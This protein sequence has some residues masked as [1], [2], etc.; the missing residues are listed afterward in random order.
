MF[1]S[2]MATRSPGRQLRLLEQEGREIAAV[3]LPL[4][5]AHARAQALEGRPLGDNSGRLR[6]AWRAATDRRPGRCFAGT[7]GGYEESQAGSAAPGGAVEA[8]TLSAASLRTSWP[9]ILCARNRH[10]PCRQCRTDSIGSASKYL[11]KQAA[12]PFAAAASD[13]AV[14]R[15]RRKWERTTELT[16]R[17]DNAR[18]VIMLHHKNFDRRTPRV[19]ACSALCIAACVCRRVCR[20]EDILVTQYKAD[21]SGAPYGVAIDKGFFKKAGVDITG[22]ISGEGGGTSVRAV[23]A[24]ALGY[25]R[26]LAGRGDR[27]HQRRPGY[28]DRR[29]RIAL[30]RRQRHH[31]DARLA[32]QVGQGP[33]GQEVRHQQSEIARRN[34]V[35]GR[36]REG[37]PRS[38][39]HPARRARQPLRRADRARKSCRRCDQHS[40]HPV[41]D[42]RRRKQI[43]RHHGTE[44]AARIAAGGRHRHQRSDEEPSRQA[45]RDSGGAARRRC[46]SSSSTPPTPA[47]FS[48]RS[49]RRCRRS[50]SIR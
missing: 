14:R 44:G 27:R 19:A 24:S 16:A 21:P 50:R 5:V 38:Q 11:A 23:I 13:N 6:A 41:H 46:N 18:E 15:A 32:D 2:M 4:G 28:Q 39:R 25:R 17:R 33:Q 31:R 45:A 3:A 7:P 48:R 1:G 37:R 47:R 26:D 30:A 8:P 36:G 40:G 10:S 43:P 9:S 29:Y 49:T 34:D 12:F 42:A 20:G 22:V 35:R